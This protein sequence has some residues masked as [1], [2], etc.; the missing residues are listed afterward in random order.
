MNSKFFRLIWDSSIWV[1]FWTISKIHVQSPADNFD[2]LSY[3]PQPLMLKGESHSHYTSQ[4]SAH[5]V[6]LASSVQLLIQRLCPGQS[7]GLLKSHSTQQ[8]PPVTQ[9]EILIILLTCI[10]WWS[11]GR[12]AKQYRDGNHIVQKR[13]IENSKVV[14]MIALSC[15]T[16]NMN[17]WSNAMMCNDRD[18]EVFG[19][20]SLYL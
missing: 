18:K 9:D 15:L 20:A 17:H 2:L 1:R 11:R 5:I 13:K 6:L 4:F 19:P 3:L 10:S 16:H 8:F 7:E 14:N 12:Q